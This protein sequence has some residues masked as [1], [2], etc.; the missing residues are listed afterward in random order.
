MSPSPR[1]TEVNSTL[2]PSHSVSAFCDGAVDALDPAGLAAGDASCAF[3]IGRETNVVAQK[4]A[5]KTN[6]GLSVFI[7]DKFLPGRIRAEVFDVLE[8]TASKV[9]VA[10]LFRDLELHCFDQFIIDIELH[11][12][13][14]RR[15]THVGL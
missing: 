15:P 8:T 6:K 14:S 9:K 5:I 3:K 1:V 11:A 12:V 7:W 4:P 2:M 10:E 13:V